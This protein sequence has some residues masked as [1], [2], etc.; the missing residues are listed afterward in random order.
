MDQPPRNPHE[1]LLNRRVLV[2]A[3]LWYGLMGSVAAMLGYFLVNLLAGWPATPLA[4]LGNDAD[5]VYIQATTMT[6]AGI[7]FA[8][9]GQVMN[10][11]TEKTSVFKIGLFSNRRIVAGIVFEIALIVFLT[12]FPPLQG[13][14]HTGPLGVQDYLFLCCIPPIVVA[15]EELR[16]AWLR[17]RDAARVHA[18]R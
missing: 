10:C 15:I 17:R 6:L 14:F 8:Q 3:F 4:G 16:K 18:E 7:V 11:R 9:I 1:R 13:V 2:K 12:L 5:P